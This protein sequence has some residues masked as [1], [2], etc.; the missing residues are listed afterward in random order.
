E[1]RQESVDRV[2]VGLSRARLIEPDLQLCLYP[3]HELGSGRLFTIEVDDP[4]RE[5]S[6]VRNPLPRREATTRS[7]I[8]ATVCV[9]SA[10][11]RGVLA[12]RPGPVSSVH[13]NAPEA[14]ELGSV[15]PS[16]GPISR[17]ARCTV[18]MVTWPGGRAVGRTKPP[19]RARLW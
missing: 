5:R 8:R 7:S 19:S 6:D 13:G 10:M 14:V 16:F 4:P 15:S 17:N 9:R 18:R 3:S 11:I 1:P 2:L 12:H